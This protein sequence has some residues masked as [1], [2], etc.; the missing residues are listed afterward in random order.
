M[1]NT[2]PVERSF[3]LNSSSWSPRP[4]YRRRRH[5]RASMANQILVPYSRNRRS[6]PPLWP[7]SSSPQ[8]TANE[9]LHSRYANPTGFNI[10]PN[11][12]LPPLLPVDSQGRA[13]FKRKPNTCPFA[14]EYVR[15]MPLHAHL[16]FLSLLVYAKAVHTVNPLSL[17]PSL[18]FSLFPSRQLLI[19]E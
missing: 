12:F 7:P 15:I 19:R 9:S 14:C 8:L 16:T 1:E 6:M 2:R 5:L 13:K 18:S 17:P 10:L 3:R 4:S 11:L